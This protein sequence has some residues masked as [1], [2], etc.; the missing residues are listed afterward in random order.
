MKKSNKIT[1]LYIISSILLFVTLVGGGVYGVYLS[2][3]FNFVRSRIN[4]ISNVGANAS[5]VS[6]GGN[7][8]F[9]TSMTG[10]IV[11]SVALIVLAVFDF[12]SLIR[13]IVFFKQFKA[14]RESSIEKDV[15]KKIKS[16]GVVI[17]FAFLIDIISIGVGVAGF[18]LNAKTFVGNGSVWVLYLIDG[19]VALFALMSFVLLIVKLKRV[20]TE[21]KNNLCLSK[22]K[23]FDLKK[24]DACFK[25][26]IDKI[27]YDLLKLKHLKSSKVISN[28]EF[29]ILRKKLFNI[30]EFEEVSKEE[31]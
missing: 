17:F 11:L 29:E 28:E 9:S 25:F 3:G 5:N 21:N 27:E 23:D 13:Q 6:F 7:A 18:F 22:K 20:K 15:E 1:I 16:K 31:K 4:G 14:V 26:D 19:L 10:V 24:M 30:E 8:N 12:V 2:V